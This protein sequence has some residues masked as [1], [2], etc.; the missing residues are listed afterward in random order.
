MLEWQDEFGK[1]NEYSAELHTLILDAW[2]QHK[3][4]LTVQP[5]G[6]SM[7]MVDFIGMYQQNL[8]TK[9]KRPVRWRTEAVG[10]GGGG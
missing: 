4:H 6:K 7:Y 9:F 3:F 2:R 1:W 10:R 8:K 5:G